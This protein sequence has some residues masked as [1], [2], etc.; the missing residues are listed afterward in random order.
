MLFRQFHLQQLGH[1][2]YLLGDE[3]AGMAIVVDPQLDPRA[4]L[5]AA[6]ASGVRIAA[7][8]DGAGHADEFWSMALMV[9]SLESHSACGNFIVPAGQFAAAV[10]SIRQREVLA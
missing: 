2:S 4:Y 1:A 8:R 3:Q 9:R 6:A 7:V 10:R 5:A